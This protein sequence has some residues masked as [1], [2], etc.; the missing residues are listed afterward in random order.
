MEINNIGDF[1]DYP[2]NINDKVLFSSG[3][4]GNDSLFTGVITGISGNNVLV[5]KDGGSINRRN[6]KALFS[7]MHLEKSMP[8]LFL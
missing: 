6:P 7:L 8:E 1:F 3:A 5:K 2:L 4:Q